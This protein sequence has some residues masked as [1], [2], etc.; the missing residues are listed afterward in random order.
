MKR[1]NFVNT[2]SRMESHGAAGKVQI[3]RETYAL[4]QDEFVCEPR[5]TVNVKGKGEM[6]V[7]YVTGEVGSR[8]TRMGE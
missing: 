4:I 7:W 8:M 6:E 3:T 5:G 1:V 2:A